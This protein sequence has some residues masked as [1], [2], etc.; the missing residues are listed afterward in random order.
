MPK[1]KN[2]KPDGTP[3]EAPAMAGRKYCY[4][5][6]DDPLT[7]KQRAV[8][9]SKGGR[10]R[11]KPDAIALWTP[12]PIESM[13]DLKIMLSELANAGMSGDVITNR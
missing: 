11:G 4:F 12:R 1:C 9:S 5:H 2:T 6:D 7:I 3:C 10:V 8:G 13:E